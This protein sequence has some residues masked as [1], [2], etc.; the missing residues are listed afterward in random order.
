MH[1]TMIILFLLHF[2]LA[3]NISFFLYHPKIFIIIFDCAIY[4]K[5]LI[6]KLFF[7]YM[8]AVHC[9][10]L[11]CHNTAEWKIYVERERKKAKVEQ[12]TREGGE[13]WLKRRKERYYREQREGLYK[14]VE[15]QSFFLSRFSAWSWWRRAG[16]SLSDNQM[17]SLDVLHKFT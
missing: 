15:V 11:Q 17:T 9:T 7:L 16:S 5:N 6:L 2:Y 12:R 3:L 1:T 10:Y 14:H 4:S 13:N 8:Y